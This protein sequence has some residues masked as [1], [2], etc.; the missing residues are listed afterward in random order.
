[1]IAPGGSTAL[2]EIVL[3]VGGI[4]ADREHGAKALEI[5]APREFDAPIELVC[6][7][8]TEPEHVRSWS[9]PLADR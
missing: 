7:V 8:L 3:Q 4:V 1:L 6:E 5:A 2:H 9:S